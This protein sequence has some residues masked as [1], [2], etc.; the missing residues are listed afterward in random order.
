MKKGEIWLVELPGVDGH[1]QH[2]RRPVILITDT[3]TSVVIVIPCT[4]NE[5]ALRFPY[6]VRL[7]SSKRSGLEIDSIALVL[8]IR[9]IDRRRLQEKIG[10]LEKSS[11]TEIEHV[12][13]DLLRL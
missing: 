11:L 13:R 1:E 4:S 3:H 7:V 12:L 9:A 5:Q 10:E 8:Q 2:G 6:T